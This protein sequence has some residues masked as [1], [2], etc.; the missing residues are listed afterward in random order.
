[1]VLPHNNGSGETTMH[2][3]SEVKS[4]C[5]YVGER[6]DECQELSHFVKCES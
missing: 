3:T 5:R 1:M 2:S 6:I 4:H